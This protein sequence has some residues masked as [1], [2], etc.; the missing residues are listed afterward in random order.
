MFNPVL[1]LL[2]LV[3]EG[4]FISA[5]RPITLPSD[6]VLLLGEIVKVAGLL[7]FPLPVRTVSASPQYSITY[8]A[9]DVEPKS[10]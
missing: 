4:S 5:S 2:I 9:F 7:E 10:P 8:C 6:F 3:A 1:N